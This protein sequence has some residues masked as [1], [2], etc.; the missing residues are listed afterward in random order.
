[1][2]TQALIIKGRGAQMNPANPYSKT[3]IS[4]DHLEGIDEEMTLASPTKVI[5][6]TAKRLINP[7]KSPDIPMDFSANP[8]QGCE[9][10]CAYCYARNSH[11]YWGYSA[12]LDFE[13]KIVVK[14]NAPA[15]LAAELNDEKWKPAMVALSGNTD[16]YQPLEKEYELTRKMLEV[17]LEFRNPV[18]IITKNSLI[19]RDIDILSELAKLNLVSVI[20]SVNTT[21]EELRRKMEPRTASFA[22]RLDVIKKLSDAGIPTGIMVA[23]IIPGLNGSDIFKIVELAAQA[24]AVSAGHN[25]VRL[26]GAVQEIFTDWLKKNYPHKA[27]K[28]LHQVKSCHGGELSDSLFGRRMHGSGAFAEQIEQMMSIAKNQFMPGRKMPGFNYSLFRHSRK[29]QLSLFDS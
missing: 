24:G 15:L 29:G 16:C 1:M 8:Y 28:V 26:N 25:I 4:V 10:G 6:E 18:G 3:H 27:Q 21:D 13:S 20:I 11:T 12:G 9:H 14:K 5:F 19:L 7:V 23:P 2:N 17:F 22:K